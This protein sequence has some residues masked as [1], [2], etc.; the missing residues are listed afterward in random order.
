VTVL[1]TVLLL[2]GAAFLAVSAVGLVRLPD[3]YTRA[4]AVAKSETLGLLLVVVGLVVLR[5]WQ[6]G[7][8]QLLLIAVFSLFAN[9]TAMHALARSALRR[10]VAPWTKGE[11]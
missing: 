4:H 2:A 8:P 3:F 10:D 6:P 1:A 9:A 11:R 5:G 7:T